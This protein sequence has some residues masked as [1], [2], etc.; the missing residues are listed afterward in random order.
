M[1]LID[2]IHGKTDGAMVLQGWYSHYD[3]NLGRLYE[4]LGITAEAAKEFNTPN[5]ES[6]NEVCEDMKT[7]DY[8]SIG[9][10]KNGRTMSNLLKNGFDVLVNDLW[11]E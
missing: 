6:F 10:F 4:A 9:A 2:L 5:M 1:K 3:K 11:G 8:Y 7:V